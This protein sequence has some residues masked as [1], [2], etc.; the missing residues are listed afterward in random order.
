M[1][2]IL[3]ALLLLL[4]AAAAAAD[5]TYTVTDFD[6]VQVDGPYEVV[7][8]TGGS[9][10]ARASGSQLALDAVTVE[11]SGGILRVHANRS[12]WGGY[13]GQ[14]VEPAR[15]RVATRE[16]KGAVVRGPGSLA[17]DRV[18]GLR[19][20]L[21]LA[22]SGRLSVGAVDADQLIVSLL[23][24]GRISLAGMAKQLHAAIQGSGDL[25]AV[26]LK[27]DDAQVDAQTSGIVAFEARRAVTLT[28]NG[29]GDVAIAGN[30]AC[31][32]KATGS[33]RIRCGRQ[34][35]SGP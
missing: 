24:A 1:I 21:S 9:S 32:I 11:V 14:P 33:G 12:A 18:R 30:A 6:R 35:P 19:A 31:T 8:T 29:P 7:V 26:A 34:G 16:L 3:P 4:P 20:D 17:I 5:R 13:P 15:I 28:A 10:G 23:G 25:D 2:R 27:V 22:G